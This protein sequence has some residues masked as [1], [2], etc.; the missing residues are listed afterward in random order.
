LKFEGEI[1]ALLVLANVSN[2]DGTL[3]A[4]LNWVLQIP[5]F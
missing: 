1:L 4:I 2:F 3:T 5:E